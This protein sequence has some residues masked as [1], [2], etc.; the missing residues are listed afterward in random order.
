MKV[1]RV[2]KDIKAGLVVFIVTGAGKQHAVVLSEP[3]EER[4][5]QVYFD[6]IEEGRGILLGVVAPVGL[7]YMTRSP[8]V[9]VGRPVGIE[10]PD[11]PFS[12]RILM[13]FPVTAIIVMARE[14]VAA[15]SG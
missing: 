12:D 3:D 7:G 8:H 6:G 2:E 9:E 1:N 15:A 14:G 5:R 10:F 11:R 4:V 13:L